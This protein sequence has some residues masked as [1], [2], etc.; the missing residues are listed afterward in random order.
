MQ[1]EAN[2]QEFQSCDVVLRLGKN[3]KTV[4]IITNIMHGKNNNSSIFLGGYF[5]QLFW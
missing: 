4:K 1:K 2:E 3:T 5:Y